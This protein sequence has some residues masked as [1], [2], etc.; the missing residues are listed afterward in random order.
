[1]DVSQA[2]AASVSS[3][4]DRGAGRIVASAEPH[5]VAGPIVFFDGE[6]GLCHR[7]VDF[8]LRR[9]RNGRLWFA[10]LQ[11]S[12][13]EALLPVETR[14]DLDSVVFWRNGC[15][16]SR[17]AAVVALLW[18]L[19]GIWRVVAAVL[20]C[21]PRPLRD[22]GYRW[23]ARNRFRWF[24]RREACRLPRPEERERFLP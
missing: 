12:T 20:W 4:D 24:G 13:A 6:C 21:V 10:P 3:S 7:T 11:G 23:V 2:N 18:T 22:L 15:G 19:G 16:Y 9:D 8:A 17:S 5:S 1:M 14:R